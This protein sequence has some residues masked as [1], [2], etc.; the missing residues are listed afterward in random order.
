MR[1]VV[2]YENAALHTFSE[3]RRRG[4]VT[5]LDAASI[6]HT[7]QDRVY[8]YTESAALH[9]QI[10]RDKDAEIA[11]ADHILCVSDLA[12]RSYIEAG[13]D[14]GK[15]DVVTLGADVER[16]SPAPGRS[17]ASG[18]TFGFV[19][20][21]DRR[22]GGDTLVAAWGKVRDR[23]PDARL[24]VIGRVQAEFRERLAVLGVEQAGQMT[25]PDVARKMR[26]V[27]TLVLPS[28][29]DSFGMVVPEAMACG[30]P[31]IVSDHVGAKDLVQEGINGWVVPVGDPEAL[32]AS[33]IHA[34]EALR[35]RPEMRQAARRTAERYTWEAYHKRV[36]AQ[37]RAWIE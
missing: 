22:K 16:F 14:P 2:A 19:G 10:T 30:V 35:E 17:E 12:R 5:I 18:H 11:L 25:Q 24:L 32:A 23:V 29:H 36:V 26:G 20:G 21:Y 3:A 8:G 15:I 28:R 27:D 33:M 7:E 9:R 4:I 37:I 6:H 13:V 31:V 34:V 1:A